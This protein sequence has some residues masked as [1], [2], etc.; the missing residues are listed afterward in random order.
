MERK[1]LAEVKLSDG[2]KAVIYDGT[3]EDFLTA[4]ETAEAVS[5]GTPSFK[6]IVIALMELLVEVDGK[7]VT[8][9]ELKKMNIRDFTKLYAS[10]LQIVG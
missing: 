6:D 10:F 8:E 9:A 7:R 2:K 1:V 3:G 4:V 5:G